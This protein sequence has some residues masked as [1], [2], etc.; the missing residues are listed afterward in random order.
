MANHIDWVFFYPHPEFSY[1]VYIRNPYSGQIGDLWDMA[2][3]KAPSCSDF[4]ADYIFIFY[5]IRSSF[6]YTTG[7]LSHLLQLS[8]LSYEPHA[9]L[10]SYSQDWLRQHRDD[11]SQ[12][13]WVSH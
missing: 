7:S 4:R 8:D 6:L 3:T 2:Q 12:R 10:L 13:A 5:I 1:D 9:T 11:E